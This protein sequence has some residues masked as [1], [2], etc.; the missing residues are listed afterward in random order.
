MFAFVLR[1]ENETSAPLL[2][3]Q[4]RAAALEPRP[5]MARMSYPPHVT[6]ALQDGATEARAREIFEGVLAGHRSVTLRFARLDLFE[7]D[8]LTL[9]A[10]PAPSRALHDLFVA[11]DAA[12]SDE[13]RH[14]HYRRGAWRPHVTLA[15]AIPA[16]REAAARRLAA[17]PIKPF[18][19]PFDDAELV[20]LPTIERLASAR[21]S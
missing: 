15:Q 12:L 17:A 9:W 19:T 7:G 13:G 5:P 16:A 8:P 18:S 14:P 11:L 1:V 21:L 4:R 3:L 2:A 6:L 20:R 10:A